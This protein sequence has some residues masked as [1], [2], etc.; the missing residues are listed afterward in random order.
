M[1]DIARRQR[2]VGDFPAISAAA[3]PLFVSVFV[4]V[5]ILALF[6]RLRSAPVSWRGRRLRV[7]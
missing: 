3:Y 6:D 5:S 1:L 4:W 2:A 7:T